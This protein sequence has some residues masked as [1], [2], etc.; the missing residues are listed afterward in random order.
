[1]DELQRY[2]AEIVRNPLLE[3]G[4]GLLTIFN[5]EQPVASVPVITGGDILDP[6]EYGGLCPA[7]QL[8]LC[9]EIHVQVEPGRNA[10]DFARLMPVDYEQTKQLFPK[11][12]W[13]SAGAWFKFHSMGRST[14]CSGPEHKYW[15]YTKDWMNIAYRH[16]VDNEYQFVLDIVDFVAM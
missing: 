9:S 13:K 16:S 14:G 10:M 3:Y 15:E 8:Y 6:T 1:M 4:P 7:V 11:R 5:N 12:T 2:S